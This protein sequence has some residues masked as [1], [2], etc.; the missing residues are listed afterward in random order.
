MKKA[1]I[2]I[3]LA[4]MTLFGL[5]A[6]TRKIE[7]SRI[8][9]TDYSEISI[10]ETIDIV[11]SYKADDASE[12]E[13]AKSVQDLMVIWTSSD[14]SVAKVNNGKVTGISFGESIISVSTEDNLLTAETVVKVKSPVE[15]V[16]IEDIEMIVHDED[17]E[18]NYS[19]IPE[20]VKANVSFKITDETVVKLDDGKIT[21]VKPG[22]TELI[23]KADDK[24]KTVKVIVKEEKKEIIKTTVTKA[25]VNDSPTN[26][27]PVVTAKP[28]PIPNP[29]PKPIPSTPTPAPIIP[30]PT[31]KPPVSIPDAPLDN[32][33]NVDDTHNPGY[34]PADNPIIED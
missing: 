32:N 10:G 31:P 21:A 15:S 8:K 3:S 9:L 17:V 4:V 27:A 7:I 28:D 6:C 25:P 20:G 23:I 13:I 12:E 26:A 14:E 34:S 5:T 33:Q 16:I 18:I 2:I 29:T 11:P 1:A 30:M 22:E 24:E 19:L